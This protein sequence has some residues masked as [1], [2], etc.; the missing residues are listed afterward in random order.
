MGEIIGWCG[1]CLGAF[2]A[3]AQLLRI[4]KTK[5]VKGISLTT[6]IFLVCAMTCY[7]LHAISIKSPVFVTAQSVNLLTNLIILVLL[8]RRRR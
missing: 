7:L 8:I 6:Y 3:P 1:F 4:I 2:V 5:E